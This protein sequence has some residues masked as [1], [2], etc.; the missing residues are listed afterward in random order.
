VRTAAVADV[1]ETV[2][3]SLGLGRKLVEVGRRDFVVV[4][5]GNDTR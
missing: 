5:T 3:D 4:V 1:G 2:D